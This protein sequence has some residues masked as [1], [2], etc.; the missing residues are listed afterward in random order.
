M[1]NNPN[2]NPANGAVASNPFRLAPSQAVTSDQD[3]AYTDEQYAYD[4][5]LLDLFPHPYGLRNVRTN[6]LL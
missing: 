4:A 5:G 3:H 2:L 1:T 6:G